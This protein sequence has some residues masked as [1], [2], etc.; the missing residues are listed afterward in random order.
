MTPVIITDDTTP[1][2]GCYN[3]LQCQ[4]VSHL[5]CVSTL[6]NTEEHIFLFFGGQMCPERLVTTH[7]N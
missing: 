4:Y 2:T 1:P 6:K 3:R 5:Q 7:E